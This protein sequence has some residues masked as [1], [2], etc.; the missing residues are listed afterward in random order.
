M[1]DAEAEDNEDDDGEKKK[2]KKKKKKHDD[3]GDDV[4]DE[5]G[6]KKKKK[7][8]KK[9]HDDEEDGD[10][11]AEDNE[12]DDGE[13][14]KKKKK[15]KKHDDEGDDVDDEDGEKKKKKKSKKKK[16]I[17]EEEDSTEITEDVSE[18]RDIEP[19]NT[20]EN[21]QEQEQEQE[22]EKSGGKKKKKDRRTGRKKT[23]VTVEATDILAA[24]ISASEVSTPAEVE[25]NGDE[26]KTKE[27][28]EK[29]TEKLEKLNVKDVPF[30]EI[31]ELKT[32]ATR[33][34][35]PKPDNLN[36]TGDY[37]SHIN[38]K[39]ILIN[40][41]SI[42]AFGQQLVKDTTLS[43]VHGRRYG[44]LGANGCGKSTLL[45][46]IARRDV[47]IPNTID[48]YVLDREFDATDMTAIE[49]V[50]D[51][52]KSERDNLEIEM[53]DI[54]AE[55][56]TEDPRLEVIMERL[57]ELDVGFAERKAKDVLRG[58][59]FSDEM[60]LMKTREF[61][62]GWRMR[63]S[64]ARALF[65]KP[66]LL[67][68]DEPTNHL[69]LGACVWLEEY[70]KQ[71]EHTLLIISHSQD[72]LNGVCT[73]IIHM[74]RGKLNYYTGDYDTFVRARAEKEAA[75]RKKQKI[76]EKQ[77]KLMQEKMQ[78]EGTRAVK[79]SKGKEKMLKER[80]EKAAKDMDEVVN[81]KQFSFKFN[82][83]GRGL[84]PPVLQVRDAD[85]GYDRE[86]ILFKD[87][88]FGLDLDSR[89]TIVGPN[90]A[91]KSTLLKLL[92]G[93]I[94][95]LAGEVKRNHHLRIAR[96]HQHLV[97]QL[98]MEQSPV[99]YMVSQFPEYKA[100]E[101]RQII[102]R[103]GLTGKSQVIPM[104]QLSDGQC[105]RVIFAWLAMRN[106]H[107]LFLDE[108][109]NHLDIETI[110]A[111]ADAIDN[112]DGGVVLIS[113]DFRLIDQVTKEIWVVENQKVTPWEGDIRDYKEYLRK[114]FEEAGGIE[115]V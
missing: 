63:I 23:R 18:S 81:E 11:E 50:V 39:D 76:Q 3:E 33:S 29:V 56:N 35:I 95:P 31:G 15:K 97:E 96:F 10:G 67:L 109:T 52:V 69:D 91:G 70:L 47:Y 113:H 80:K 84:P 86:H 25:S 53:E 9:K 5:D 75:A 44:L 13:K 46:V 55:G 41:F 73:D 37:L 14:K 4:D 19:E 32:R 77:N 83:C 111:L 43:L 89:V 26:D 64:L 106:P 90:G 103:F 36:V 34:A 42:S 16:N 30:D 40:N 71:Y 48:I 94:E 107:I 68:L 87:I 112:F 115:L 74:Q 104:N 62:G 51:I 21:K 60:L 110:D 38:S 1:K 58:L 72:F 57:N 59:G 105:R 92:V 12:D 88:N 22:Q 78:K 17:E 85:F 54:L 100:Q 82:D 99:E 98:N 24:A 108:P 61:S 114:Q 7:K 27:N 8:K 28:I 101:M 65:V 2:K 45:Q 93:Q 20:E 66:T 102:G 6:E 79:Q 49:A